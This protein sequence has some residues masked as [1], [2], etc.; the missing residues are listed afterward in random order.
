MSATL[1]LFGLTGLI[2][3][4][5]AGRRQLRQGFGGQRVY[6]RRGPGLGGI[7]LVIFAVIYLSSHA[8][9]VEMA[10]VLLG[11]TVGIGVLA[12]FLVR[13]VLLKRNRQSG[14]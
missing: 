6:L 7:A 13:R 3:W 9:L 5:F 8:G 4:L 2:Y 11:V 12:V 14:P 10:L 1:I